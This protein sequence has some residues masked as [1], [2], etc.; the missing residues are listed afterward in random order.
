MAPLNCVW[1]LGGLGPL[2]CAGHYLCVDVHIHN[3]SQFFLPHTQADYPSVG[4]PVHPT[5]FLPMKT[6][7]SEEIILNWSLSQPPKHSLTIP[8]LLSGEATLGRRIGMIIDLANHE[9]LY[10][11][12]LPP[13]LEYAHIQL[14]AKVLPP[15]EAIDEVQLTAQTFWARKPHEYIAIHCAYGFNRTGFVV[16]SYLCQACGMTVAQ[17][18]ESFAAARPPGVKHMKFVDELY[19]RYGGRDIE[20]SLPAPGSE[21]FPKEDILDEQTSGKPKSIQKASANADVA[22]STRVRES[23]EQPLMST[24]AATV[25]DVEPSRV[26]QS[27]D[28]SN[29]F[30]IEGEELSHPRDT[31]VKGM[32]IS[33]DALRA[34]FDDDS[35]T[36]PSGGSP[37][38]SSSAIAIKS[39][40][41]HSPASSDSGG[42][43]LLRIENAEGGGQG[44]SG[45]AVKAD[46]VQGNFSA[47]AKRLDEKSLMRLETSIGLAKALHEDFGVH[48]STP[49][50]SD[51]SPLM[52]RATAEEAEGPALHDGEEESTAPL[53]TPFGHPRELKP[54]EERANGST[55]TVVSDG[56]VGAGVGAAGLRCDEGARSGQPSSGG[57]Y[58]Y[59][60]ATA[61]AL[62][63]SMSFESDNHSL[64]F[65]A[66]EAMV[67]LKGAA[68]GANLPRGD[69][70]TQ[71]AEMNP[72]DW[73][74][75]Q[76]DSTRAPRRAP[77]S[78][79]APAVK[80]GNRTRRGCRTM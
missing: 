45:P 57:G 72:D 69:T 63:R 55:C 23:P 18:L 28:A 76:V 50:Q 8:D 32:S 56:N 24:A 41:M 47:M 44:E 77:S 68:K 7:M 12:D 64:G 39:R 16:C 49:G 73:A 25:G 79:R 22:D 33:N 11:D 40:S 2:A 26:G 13:D 75:E 59:D 6:P 48:G 74:V 20:L 52:V 62:K 51:P 14:V 61:A 27:A 80:E 10:A 38:S 19:A 71:L 30:G 67:H 66:R 29:D 42:A 36:A 53:H 1:G 5:S 17:A 3:N 4:S 21:N 37:S 15:Q 43:I 70:A 54:T 46:T 31:T 34:S 65:S 35:P 60:A 78:A 58:K 9:C